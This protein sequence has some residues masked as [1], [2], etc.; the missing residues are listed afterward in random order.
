M[1]NRKGLGIGGGTV[2]E[3]E[4]Q[5]KGGEE[6]KVE[7]LGWLLLYGERCVLADEMGRCC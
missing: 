5:R 6:R 1:R 3:K 7:H 2:G 4:N